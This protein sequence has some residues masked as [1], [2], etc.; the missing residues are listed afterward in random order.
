TFK[1]VANITKDID[2]STLGAVNETLFEAD[3]E[4]ALFSA[5]NRVSVA[6]YVS[7]EE[8]LDALLGLKPQLDRFFDDV[9]VNAE[10]VAVRTNR[11]TL[12]AYIYRSILKIADIKEVSI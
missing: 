8:E 4:S 11:K 10:D 2:L 6:S 1:R 9:M 5:Y 7:Y 3:A 12:V